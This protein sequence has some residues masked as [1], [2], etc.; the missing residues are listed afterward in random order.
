[1]KIL[2]LRYLFGKV[3]PPKKMTLGFL[4]LQGQRDIACEAD[5]RRIGYRPE[6]RSTANKK[7]GTKAALLF[8]CIRPD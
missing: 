3:F 1:V 6:L 4:H 5:I 2:P 7:R 8:L